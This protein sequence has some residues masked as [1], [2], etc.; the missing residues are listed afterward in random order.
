MRDL[1]VSGWFLPFTLHLVVTHACTTFCKPYCV[2]RRISSKTFDFFLK[3]TVDGRNPAPLSKAYTW[4]ILKPR[5]P[6]LLLF[7]DTVIEMD[8]CVTEIL[9]HLLT[10]LST[11]SLGVRGYKLCISKCKLI[12]VVQ[13]F[14]HPP[15]EKHVFLYIW[16]CR[17][18]PAVSYLQ[19]INSIV[20]S[21]HSSPSVLHPSPAHSWARNKISY[22]AAAARNIA[23]HPQHPR[24]TTRNTTRYTTCNCAGMLPGAAFRAG[25]EKSSCIFI[26]FPKSI[27]TPKCCPCQ[28]F[29]SVACRVACN[30]ACSVARSVAW[31]CH[32]TLVTFMIFF[33]KDSASSLLLVRQPFSGMPA[34]LCPAC[35]AI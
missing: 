6:N 2:P 5:V 29:G 19:G 27:K 25:T 7:E 13:D 18:L 33:E 30:V 34:L 35:I 15:K 10:C 22:M 11:L 31:G 26:S 9:Q 23:N 16:F 12:E 28:Q 32:A 8:L 3:N 14:F 1:L 21:S 24:Y 17:F 20:G 4:N